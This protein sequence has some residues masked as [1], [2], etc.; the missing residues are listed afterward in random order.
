MWIYESVWSNSLICSL[1]YPVSHVLCFIWIPPPHFLE[2]G[3]ATCQSLQPDSVCR[4]CTKKSTDVYL[5][6]SYYK[7][8]LRNLL[9]FTWTVGFCCLC[10]NAALNIYRVYPIRSTA[11]N[12]STPPFLIFN[13]YVTKS[14]KLIYF[15]IKYVAFCMDLLQ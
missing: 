5:H 3:A 2:H 6:T 13:S 14:L 7:K 9:E 4:F 12:R 11:P 1:T 10:I 8:K 15:T